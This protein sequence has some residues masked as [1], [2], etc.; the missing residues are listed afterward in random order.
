MII[1][2]KITVYILV[3]YLESLDNHSRS[4]GLF[5]YVGIGLIFS[6]NLYVHVYN[7]LVCTLAN[8]AH[9]KRNSRLH[10]FDSYSENIDF[11]SFVHMAQIYAL[12]YL[13]KR[14][15]YLTTK[16]LESSNKTIENLNRQ[17][18]DV[19]KFKATFLSCFSHEVR[20]PLNILTGSIDVLFK[21]VKEKHLS[22]ILQGAKLS[23]D[24]LLKLVNNVLDAANL[25]T[26]K[27]ELNYSQNNVRGVIAHLVHMSLE[28]LNNKKMTLQVHVDK[29]IPEE[30]NIDAPRILQLLINLLSN[31]I[32]FS[33]DGQ[34]VQ[35]YFSW[36][37]QCSLKSELLELD[38]LHPSTKRLSSLIRSYSNPNSLTTS[39]GLPLS[40][41]YN[42][43]DSLQEFGQREEIETSNCEWTLKKGI[44]T[45]KLETPLKKI[46]M[47]EINSSCEK[48]RHKYTIIDTNAYNSL[49]SFDT[50]TFCRSNKPGYLKV[51][52]SDQG[53]GISKE[54][55]AM[56]FELFT[57]VDS[58]ITRKNS[59][60][61]LGLWVTK[62]IIEKMGGEIKLYS[63]EQ[64]GS[65]FVFYI[66]VVPAEETM[67]T[68]ASFYEYSMKPKS[69]KLR[70]L[71]VD[72]IKF[73]RDL[74]K[75]ML[76]NEGVE[77]VIAENGLEAVNIY[78]NNTGDFFDFILT[79]LQMPIMDG[80]TASRE[81]RSFQRLYGRKEVE[82]YIISGNC[83]E[84]EIREC[85]DPSRGIGA[86]DFLQKPVNNSAI[87]NIVR[88]RLKRTLKT[89]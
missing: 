70:A 29:Q 51:E 13:M 65:S 2:F 60:V 42:Y 87:K 89:I 28:S 77:V 6:S 88:K 75:I 11:Y 25:Q 83:S 57:P 71:I 81:I 4:S 46:S 8:F 14:R 64:K 38:V 31:S 33:E 9:I 22:Q 69:S 35:I 21:T 5:L 20:N 30:V 86:R 52:I 40:P 73:N 78:K 10:F 84:T 44:N 39:P 58:S 62:Q 72:D 12:F 7:I 17:L 1:C 49:Q 34:L 24:L 3:N 79:D 76:E 41:R 23:A 50:K 53:C 47:G 54:D 37:N 48:L 45:S 67:L 80:V 59:G 82:I 43:Q 18:S 15:E 63:E 66:P 19:G 61:G 56:L 27:F 26:D 32:K 68:M 85:T 74:L 55:Q 36:H 16:D